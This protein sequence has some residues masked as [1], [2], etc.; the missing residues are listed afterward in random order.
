MAAGD[1]SDG[2]S[3]G[4]NGKPEGER[5]ASISDA[6]IGNTRSHHRCAASA[7]HQPE[8]SKEFRSCTFTDRL[9]GKDPL[10]FVWV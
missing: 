3:H 1:V 9:H 8:S 4:Q 2:E 5:D 7:K 6:D 10:A